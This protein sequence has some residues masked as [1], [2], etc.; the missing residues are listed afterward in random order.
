MVKNI[1]TVFI[2]TYNALYNGNGSFTGDIVGINGKTVK[3]TGRI[4]YVDFDTPPI[5]I[6]NKANLKVANYCHSGTG[7][8]DAI[9][10]FKIVGVMTDNSKYIS[11]DSG[12][13]TILATTCNST[14]NIY[15][16]NDIPLV[17]QTINSIRLFMTDSL[18][19]INVGISNEMNF[20]ISL[21]I[22]E[23]I[24]EF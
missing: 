2:N 4:F 10:I 5:V 17:K 20:C 9:I 12:I 11:N 14:R 21:K 22:E 19:D 7:H 15:E 23:E 3:T 16:E 6:K 8:G 13:P 1:T 18:T 24:N